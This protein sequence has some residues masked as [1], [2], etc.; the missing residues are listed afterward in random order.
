MFN[1]RPDRPWL[2]AG[3]TERLL[4][5]EIT[6]P[7]P[8][9]SLARKPVHLSLVIDRSGSMSGE[10]LRLALEAARQAIRTLQPGDRFSVVTFD[11]QVE[12]PIPSTEATPG[13]RLRAEAALDTV[14]ARGNTDLGGGW[15]RGCAE[16]S[17]H[18]PEDAIGRV[19]LLTDG[20]AN[21]GITSPDELTSRARAQRLRRV[22]T[23]T[24]GLGEGF[25]EF[26]LG[27]L[28][29]EG[30]GNFYFAARADELPGFVGREIGEVLSVVARDAALVIRAPGGVEVASLNDYP[31]TRDG[32]TCSFSLGSLPGGRV[33][34]P[35][36][37]LRFPAG[38]L[39]ETLVVD[40]AL[41]DR[42][43]ALTKEP[44]TL[45]WPRVAEEQ[46]RAQPAD[47]EVLR[48]AAALDA[49]RARRVAL[50]L[51]DDRLWQEA[52][53]TLADAASR[54]RGYADGDPE[55]RAEADRL[56]AERDAYSRPMS[57]LSKKSHYYDAM[58]AMKMGGG[59][60]GR[61][62]QGPRVL[63][64]STAARLAPLLQTASQAL[65]GVRGAP[66]FDVDVTFPGSPLPAGPLSQRGEDELVADADALDPGALK[67]VFV[68][69]PLTDRWFSHWH[70][71]HRTAVISLAG[72]DQLISLPAASFVAY[73]LLLYGLHALSADYEPAKLLHTET[74][75]CLFDLCQQKAEVAIKLQAGHICAGCL[76]KLSAVGLDRD[77]VTQ[78]WRAVQA[79]AQSGTST[80]R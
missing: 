59:G 40:V 8:E 73:E 37:R 72:L 55:I 14:T 51:N 2:P 75:A 66:A 61:A 10:K 43:G 22:T 58:M 42:D 49:A 7:R 68:E 74:L 80:G 35:M 47:P 20:Q 11:H 67:V 50:G 64:V 18:L 4:R 71:G 36:F 19:L 76:G 38:A 31:C 32:G 24:I 30:G 27:R 65:G 41:T 63:G 79:L 52:A 6:V 17:A 3:P 57:S 1:A 62:R 33:L 39:G 15:L 28:S 69:Q 29:E 13:A 46:A 34:A 44:C 48:A 53:S 16:V 60:R 77:V 54:L 25:N 78:L 26:L 9:G 5:V 23:S 56:D 21:H 45:A 12:V 70:P